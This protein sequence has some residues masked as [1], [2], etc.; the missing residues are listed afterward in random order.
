M[1]T[2]PCNNL[3]GA[4]LLVPLDCNNPLE[5][6]PHQGG[7]AFTCPLPA[8]SDD[9]YYS[10]KVMQGV[11]GWFSWVG[12]VFLVFN[13][14]LIPSLRRFP[15]N[16]I[17]MTAIAAN[18]AA[19][20]IILPTYAGYDNIWCGGETIYFHPH[21]DIPPAPPNSTST[22]SQDFV[23]SFRYNELLS[24]SSACTFQGAMLQFGYLAAT[25]WWGLIA[26]NIFM[27]VCF[28]NLLKLDSAWGKW[29]RIIFY[30]VVGWGVPF[31][32]MVIPASADRIKFAPG[33]TYCF[34][35]AEDNQAYQLTFWFLPVGITLLLGFT[36]FTVAIIRIT[37]MM[38]VLRK[39]DQMWRYIRLLVF[40]FLYLF[41]FC[42][43]FSYHIQLEVDR[44]T[45]TDGYADYFHCLISPNPD[46][47]HLSADVSN[48]SLVML[49][50]FAISVL[51][52][53]LFL[54]FISWEILR[55]W[56]LAISALVLLAVHRNTA[57]AM[58]VWNLFSSEG[59][60]KSSISATD[61][62]LSTDGDTTK[63]AG[64]AI[65][66]E[67]EDAIGDEEEP[68][69]SEESSSSSDEGEDVEMDKVK[70]H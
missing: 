50:G 63:T 38:F 17:L 59:A 46:S 28:M 5:Y 8:L 53:L 18:I 2:E 67:E 6:D 34:V 21:Y 35:S 45:I 3:T 12:T 1:V 51:G 37:V 27:E 65:S 10:A 29:A 31:V 16:M 41:L 62:V 14:V 33:G 49:K 22:Q 68:S 36:F 54:V 57:Q 4:A 40:I 69:H 24:G 11:I 60:V 43:I 61:D 52:F 56:Y 64:S 39:L 23:I 44:T 13:Y 48:Y 32:L 55:F 58:I 20:A 26:L 70:H 9:E 19:G 15:K 66:G 42:F 30:H 47:C 7:C 25:F